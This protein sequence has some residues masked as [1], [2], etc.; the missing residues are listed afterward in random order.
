M[1]RIGDTAPDFELKDQS[2]SIVTLDQLAADGDLILYFYPADFS[3]VCTAEAC[4]FRDNYD[5]VSSVGTQIV[6]VSPQDVGSHRRFSNSF[7]IP[8]PLLSDPRKKVIRAYGVDGP[9][10]FGVRR[11][12]FLIDSSKKIRNRVVS[13]LFVESHTELL[14]KT[15]R[16][17]KVA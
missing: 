16:E 10:G 6:G 2:G 15:L 9:L 3:P 1:L 8:F 12:T 4:A 14:K 17:R 7:S 5:G 11:V 13:D